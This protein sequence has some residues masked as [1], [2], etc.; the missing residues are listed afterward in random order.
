MRSIPLPP[1][2]LRGRPEAIA[3][4]R[5]DDAH[6]LLTGEALFYPWQEGA[7]ILTQATGFPA[8]GFYAYHIHEFGSCCTGGDVPFSCAGGHYDPLHVPHPGHA[9]D[10]PPLLACGGR[11]YSLFFTGRFRPRDVLGRS[12]VLHALPDDFSTQPSG[13]AGM[14]IACGVIRAIQ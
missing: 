9:G 13:A 6:P 1:V 5:G 12:A 11:A 7:L 2:L 4:L 8:D 14:R 3:L 10:L